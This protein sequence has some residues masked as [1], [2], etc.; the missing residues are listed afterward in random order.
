MGNSF[1]QA[2][3]LLYDAGHQLF[4][5]FHVLILLF[6]F[7]AAAHFL[8]HLEANRKWQIHQNI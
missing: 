4:Y 5:S 1:G 7:G 6:Y 8:C 3:V 2:A